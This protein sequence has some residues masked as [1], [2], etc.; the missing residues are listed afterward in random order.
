MSIYFRYCDIVVLYDHCEGGNDPRVKQW[1]I[2][3]ANKHGVGCGV[4]SRQCAEWASELLFILEESVTRNRFSPENS[5]A[6]PSISKGVRDALRLRHTL[7]KH[8]CFVHSH[9]SARSPGQ[10]YRFNEHVSV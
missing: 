8:I 5:D 9:P 7:N 6:H 3:G 4:K 1:H 2:T 10:K